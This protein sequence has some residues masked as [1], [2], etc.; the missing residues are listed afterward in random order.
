MIRS[1]GT[2]SG[3]ECA[4]SITSVSRMKMAYGIGDLSKDLSLGSKLLLNVET[5]A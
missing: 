4:P 1:I 2:L 3:V 5:A